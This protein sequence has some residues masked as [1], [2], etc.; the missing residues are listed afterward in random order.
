M[1][2]PHYMRTPPW[3]HLLFLILIALGCMIIGVVLCMGLIAIVYG[4]SMLG[5]IMDTAGVH[6]KDYVSAFRLFLG[7]GNTFLGYFVPALIF[8]FFMVKK[9]D[10]Y[11]KYRSPTP[12][13]LL[14]LAL[15]F[16]VFFLPVIDITS[17]YNQ[18]LS[19]GGPLKGLENW[20]RELEKQNEAVIKQV[21][22]M[23]THTDLYIT[24]FIV[25]FLPALSEEFLF[26]GCMQTVFLR[27]TKNTHAAVWITAFIFSF[28]HFEFLGFVPRFLLGAGLGYLCAW[29]GSIW[30]SVFV[31]FLNNTSA[32]LGMYLYQHHLIK[33]NPDGSDRMF[34]QLWI[35][36]LCFAASALVLLLY[37]KIAL[38]KQLV[39]DGEELD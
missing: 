9:P 4:S 36:V 2:V 15:V 38:Q 22:D 6:S 3:Q 10:A 34:S 28:I 33:L 19:L 1:T 32:V 23:K 37:H 27:W 25:G 13:V 18:R 14:L 12:I 31:H 8:A 21:L 35:Y 16:M 24:I 17:F 39:T 20:M 5:E 29:S 7:L 26:R 11:L 30:P